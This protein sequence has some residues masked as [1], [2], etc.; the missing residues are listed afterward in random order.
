M[1]AKI[2]T[3]IDAAADDEAAL[4]E[5]EREV[6][7]AETAI[8]VLAVERQEVALLRIAEA[9]GQVIDFRHDTSPLAVLGCRLITAPYVDPNYDGHS[10]KISYGG[11]R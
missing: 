9:K 7:A 3:E 1:I 4:S 2:E 11:G 5:S 8:D 10:F 6:K